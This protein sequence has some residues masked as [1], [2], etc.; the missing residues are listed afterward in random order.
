MTQYYSDGHERPN[1]TFEPELADRPE[2]T[3]E[4]YQSLIRGN[5]VDIDHLRTLTDFRLLRLGWIYDLNFKPAIREVLR[6]RYLDKIRETLPETL[7]IEKIFR[8]VNDY[9]SSRLAP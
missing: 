1:H 9:I 4:V 3:E 6:R 7:E 8:V 2:V 5:I